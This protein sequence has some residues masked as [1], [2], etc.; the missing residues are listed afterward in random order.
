MTETEG[1]EY[2]TSAYTESPAESWQRLFDH[3]KELYEEAADD[4]IIRLIG[5]KPG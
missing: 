5:K 4:E 1:Y 2:V 3:V